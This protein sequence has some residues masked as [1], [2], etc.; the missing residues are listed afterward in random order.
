[1]IN[2]L[3]ALSAVALVS[4]AQSSPPHLAT[5]GAA[6]RRPVRL[7]GMDY[8]P[9]RRIILS[10]GWVPAH[11]LCRDMTESECASFPEI[12]MCSGVFPAYCGMTFTRRNRCL[13]VTTSAGP[14]VAGQEES[15]THIVSV[16][17]RRG[18]CFHG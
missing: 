15:D 1:M 10:Y 11:G 8:V 17:F 2:V 5:T 12:D 14:P 18:P 16:E 13:Y 7:E 6:S 3:F 4:P 9:A